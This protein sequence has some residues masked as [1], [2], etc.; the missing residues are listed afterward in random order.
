MKYCCEYFTRIKDHF[1]WMEYFDDYGNGEKIFTMPNLGGVRINHC[2]VCG[3]DVREIEINQS[4]W[5]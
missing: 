4:D 5:T 1:D 2:P 3:G